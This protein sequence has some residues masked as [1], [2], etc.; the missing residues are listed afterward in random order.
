MLFCEGRSDGG[1]SVTMKTM[2]FDLA[3]V[4][5]ATRNNVS[6]LATQTSPES[7]ASLFN[8]LLEKLKAEKFSL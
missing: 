4:T 2:F 5:K 3:T 8:F 7:I 1:R 6:R